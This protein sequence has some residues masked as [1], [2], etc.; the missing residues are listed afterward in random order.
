MA[1]QLY[2]DKV[3]FIT[4]T[5]KNVWVIPQIKTTDDNSEYNFEGYNIESIIKECVP[6][7]L[8]EKF[9]IILNICK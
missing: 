6:E 9:E 3:N 5:W 4:R 8:K 1:N 7:N 2:I